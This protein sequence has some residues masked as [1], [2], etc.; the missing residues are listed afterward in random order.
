MFQLPPW[1]VITRASPKWNSGITWD[2]L[3]KEWGPK[4]APGGVIKKLFL[5]FS[6]NSQENTHARVSFLIK[7]QAWGLTQLQTLAQVSCE[8]YK[9]FKNTFF[10]RTPPDDCFWRSYQLWIISTLMFPNLLWHPF[11]TLFN[12]FLS[13]PLENIRKQGVF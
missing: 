8:F 2:L 11:Y 12:R 1:Q 4:T 3:R 7:L 6:Q 13:V 9:S 5:K 10:Y